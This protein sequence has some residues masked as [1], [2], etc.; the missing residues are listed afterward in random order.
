MVGWLHGFQDNSV[1]AHGSRSRWQR[2]P[3]TSRN[4]VKGRD[5]SPTVTLEG[6]A[7]RD[8]RCPTRPRLSEGPPPPSGPS[9]Y[10]VPL[11]DIPVPSKSR[12]AF[13]TIFCIPGEGHIYHADGQKDTRRQPEIRAMAPC[14][15]ERGAELSPSAGLEGSGGHSVHLLHQPWA[16]PFDWKLPGGA[17]TP[18]GLLPCLADDGEVEVSCLCCHLVVSEAGGPPS[19]RRSLRGQSHQLALRRQPVWEG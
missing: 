1:A 15:V 8:L 7:P 9:L 18:S 6:L 11:G 10:G 19:G 16:A 17:P 12:E 3:L 4:G 2:K 14:Q 13:G 5:K